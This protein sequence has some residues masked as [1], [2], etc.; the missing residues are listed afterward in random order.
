MSALER[1]ATSAGKW[2]GTNSL[3]LSPQ[4]PVQESTSTLSLAAVANGKFIEVRYTWDYE[5]Q[6]QTGILLIGYEA[7]REL[8]NAVWIDSWHMGEKFMHCQGIIK[9]NGNI[10][11]RGQYHAPPGPDWGWRIVIA[12]E[13]ENALNLT[14]YNIAPEGEEALAVKAAYSRV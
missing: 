12:P 7:E 8:V 13:A 11:V 4:S 9:E 5:N 10:N 2:Q 1:L 6:P 3:W 14:M